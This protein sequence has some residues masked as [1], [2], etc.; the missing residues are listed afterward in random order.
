MPRS[1]L[2]SALQR[3]VVWVAYAVQLVHRA[4]VR[5]LRVEAA[6]LIKIQHHRQLAPYAAD[7][8]DLPYQGVAEALL[9]IQAVIEEVR[10]PEILVDRVYVVSVRAAAA[11]RRASSNS[12]KD[13]LVRLPSEWGS[14]AVVVDRLWPYRIVRLAIGAIP[15][16][17]QK[18]IHVDL[19]VE[20]PDSAAHHQVVLRPRLVGEADARS[21]IVSVGREDAANA[22]A[23]NLQPLPWNKD[24]E[25]LVGTIQRSDIVVP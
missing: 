20:Q 2:E 7:I 18:R 8:A 10:R 17:I 25:V 4:D 6:V 15:T 23:L 24:R 5:I 12:R 3:V 21:E 9:D 11:G 19:V 14:D 16:V 1:D 22:I 13:V